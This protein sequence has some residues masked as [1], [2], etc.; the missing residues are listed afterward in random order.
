MKPIVISV[1]DTSL[2]IVLGIDADAPVGQ[3][4]AAFNVPSADRDEAVELVP[5]EGMD[6]VRAILGPVGSVP[7]EPRI[8]PPRSR[9]P[10]VSGTPSGSHSSS[11]TPF[12]PILE[13]H[14]LDIVGANAAADDRSD[15]RRSAPGQSPPP[16]RT[17]RR[18]GPTL[19][20]TPPRLPT[21]HGLSLR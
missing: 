19:R 16:V 13:A 14:E 6:P 5:F 21:G 9:I 17:P 15:R 20:R 12:H 11:S 7:D 10:L 3:G 18:M 2:S 4:H 8:V 1:P